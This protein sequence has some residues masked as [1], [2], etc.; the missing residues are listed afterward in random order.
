MQPPTPYGASD[1]TFKLNE[2]LSAWKK[3]SEFNSVCALAQGASE[4]AISVL[5]RSFKNIER[6]QVALLRDRARC[7]SRSNQDLLALFESRRWNSAQSRGA[8]VL[9]L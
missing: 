5:D 8:I 7:A 4:Q 1:Q 6:A 9:D 3:A 2:L